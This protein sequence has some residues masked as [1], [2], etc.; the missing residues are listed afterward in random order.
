MQSLRELKYA[1]WTN[2]REYCV[3]RGFIYFAACGRYIK[4][5]FSINPSRR[6]KLIRRDIRVPSDLDRR[7]NITLLKLTPGTTT[8]EQRIH[9][10]LR[11][12]HVVCPEAARASRPMEWYLDTP[13]LRA[14]VATLPCHD[15][16]PTSE[17]IEHKPINP[18]AQLRF[19]I[20]QPR[21]ISF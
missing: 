13:E 5:G 2:H 12:E 9:R 11:D 20:K 8:D 18:N 3:P 15:Y 10:Q 17:Q 1:S 4:V 19:R 7:A 16:V 6:V 14:F 21:H